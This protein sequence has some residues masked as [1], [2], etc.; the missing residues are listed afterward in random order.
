MKAKTICCELSFLVDQVVEKESLCTGYCGDK[1]VCNFSSQDSVLIG[2]ARSPMSQGL[3]LRAYFISMKTLVFSCL[4]IVT[5]LNCISPAYAQVSQLAFRVLNI[6]GKPIMGVELSVKGSNVVSPPT[7][8]AGSTRINLPSNIRPGDTVCLQV[9]GVNEDLIFVSPLGGCIVVPYLG[10]SSLTTESIVLGRRGEQRLL[11]EELTRKKDE[12]AQ[13]AVALGQT[14]YEQGKYQQSVSSY[15]E[16]LALRPD[17][18][19]I[20]VGLGL[21]LIKIGNYKEAETLYHRALDIREKRLGAAHPEVARTLNALG[22]LYYEQGRYVEAEALYRR[23]LSIMEKTS[24]PDHAVLT[25]TLNGLGAL[26]AQKEEYVQAI[27]M[28]QRALAIENTS[29]SESPNV[30][31]IYNNLGNLYHSMG[32]ISA[33]QDLYERALMILEKALGPSHPEVA[34]LLDNLGVLYSEKGDYRNSEILFKRALEVKESTPRPNDLDI[35]YSLNNIAVLYLKKGD[36]AKAEPYL[37]RS[38]AIREKVASSNDPDVAYSLGNLGDLYYMKGDYSKAEPLYQRAFKMIEVT[39][40]SEHPSVLIFMRRLA[41]LYIA[42][43]DYKSAETLYERALKIEENILGLDRATL[44]ITLNEYAELLFKMNRANEATKLIERAKLA[45]NNQNDEEEIR[46]IWKE[47]LVRKRRGQASLRSPKFR[48]ASIPLA[49]FDARTQVEPASEVNDA[50]IGVT[51]WRLRPSTRNDE[52]K[53]LVHEPITSESGYREVNLT[54]VR[55]EADTPINEGER[56]RISIESSRAG[57][58]YVVNREEYADGSKGPA[59]LI[60]PTR[61]TMEGK[62]RVRAGRVI[63]IPANND[64]PSYF[65]VRPNPQR[66]NQVAELLLVI[67]SDQPLDIPLTVEAQDLPAAMVN[68]WEREWAAQAE[69]F[70]LV[71]GVGTPITRAEVEAKNNAERELGQ[72]DPVPQSIYRVRSRK[73]APSLLGLRLVFKARQSG[74]RP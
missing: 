63:T 57:Y 3:N 45:L 58:L 41:K 62:N 4:L 54:A 74:G 39:L 8:K 1:S 10:N 48:R 23:S 64:E 16:A 67:V 37:L 49:S 43:G 40:G 53:E 22:E 21:T 26:F 15:Q 13:A 24:P 14:F 5:I 11:A 12:L 31:Y 44:A 25:T 7:D 68:G 34:L 46:S 70:E 18:D 71:G 28:Y 50:V 35:A 2:K 61:R 73:G 33:A 56:V 59:R 66:K 36:Y 51:V 29:S 65:T 72:N 19:A 69:R 38:L 42:R 9:K 30:A 6:E 17:D 60:F 55:M 47:G 52:V 20:L 32:N 27:E